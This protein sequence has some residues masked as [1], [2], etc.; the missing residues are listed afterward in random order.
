M[1]KTV[2]TAALPYANGELHLGHIKSTYLPADIYTRFLK[3]TGK[4]AIYLC[5]TDEHGTPILFKSEE[6]KT[7]P[8][9]YI[10]IWRKRHLEDL[11]FVMIDFDYFYA[12]HSPEH[13]ELTQELY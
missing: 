11:G 1:E 9:E 6:K 2:V 7:A 8:E 12:T 10:K 3:F 13:I 5:A 4:N